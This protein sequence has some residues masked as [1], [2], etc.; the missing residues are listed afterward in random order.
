MSDS[1]VFS[2]PNVIR[3]NVFEY[4]GFCHAPSDVPFTV[5]EFDFQRVQKALHC[6][7]KSNTILPEIRL[8]VTAHP[9]NFRLKAPTLG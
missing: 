4:S 3:F 9:S 5:N 8:Y 7:S 2:L 1:R 6:R